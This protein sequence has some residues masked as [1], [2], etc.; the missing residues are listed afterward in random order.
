MSRFLK[1]IPN[2]FIWE[3][4]SL[5]GIFYLLIQFINAIGFQ[6]TEPHMI[7]LPLNENYGN[8]LIVFQFI[9]LFFIIKLK[10]RLI[11]RADLFSSIIWFICALQT[12]TLR[13]ND[14]AYYSLEIIAIQF[15]AMCF[16]IL[17]FTLRKILI[18]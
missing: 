5:M 18:K 11:N 12:I 6:T 13:Y 4:S 16:G 3:L 2:Q 15:F 17:H 1:P 8:Q 10:K 7:R 14:H 9:I